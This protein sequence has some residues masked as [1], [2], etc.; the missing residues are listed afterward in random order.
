MSSIQ[1]FSHRVSLKKAEE[2]H[3]YL[4]NNLAGSSQC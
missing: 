4:E 2:V 1:D 3:S